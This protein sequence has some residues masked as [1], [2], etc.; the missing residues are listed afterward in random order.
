[1]SFEGIQCFIIITRR[2][3]SQATV[4]EDM[5]YA[6]PNIFVYSRCESIITQ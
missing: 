1:M 6:E 5:D 4:A 2:L 3:D